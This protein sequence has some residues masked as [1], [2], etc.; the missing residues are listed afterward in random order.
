MLTTIIKPFSYYVG[1]TVNEFGIK[2]T[3]EVK[4]AIKHELNGSSNKGRPFHYAVAALNDKGPRKIRKCKYIARDKPSAQGRKQS[5]GTVQKRLARCQ[6][7]WRKVRHGT[8]L[9]ASGILMLEGMKPS[10]KTMRKVLD[11]ML[12]A[13]NTDYEN[14]AQKISPGYKV[15]KFVQMGHYKLAEKGDKEDKEGSR[16]EVEDD[17]EGDTSIMGTDLLKYIVDDKED[18]EGFYQEVENDGEVQEEL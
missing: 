10:E 4:E 5:S 3:D 18:E 9:N 14:D 16:Q 1:G 12:D 11:H 17:M 2:I 7:K 8:W 13:I 15:K 6:T